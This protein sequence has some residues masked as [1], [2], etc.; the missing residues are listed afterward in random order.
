VAPQTSRSGGLDP[1]LWESECF[2]LSPESQARLRSAIVPIIPEFNNQ[3]PQMHFVYLGT[4]ELG[5]TFDLHDCLFGTA[6]PSVLQGTAQFGR[7]GSRL[8]HATI[9]DCSRRKRKWN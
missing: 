7:L 8:L 5:H 9:S 1:G 3:N 4:H 6:A 2:L